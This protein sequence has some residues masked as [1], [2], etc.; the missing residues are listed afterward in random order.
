[1]L[2]HIDINELIDRCRNNDQ[3]S[4][5]ELYMRYSKAMLNTSYRITGDMQEAEDV[6]QEAFIQVFKNLSTMDFKISFGSWLKRI[7][8]NKSIDVLRKRKVTFTDND[9]ELDH[10]YKDDAI[11]EEQ[12]TLQV[13]EVKRALAELPEKYRIVFNLCTFE[14]ISQEEVAGMLGV[15]HNVVRTQYHR[16]KQ[17]IIQSLNH[18]NIYE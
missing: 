7:V 3:A 10:K 16:A 18:K 9:A 15:S 2:R 4:Y 1:M 8:I 11:D 13:K 12:A 17:K 14:D 6:L 5:R